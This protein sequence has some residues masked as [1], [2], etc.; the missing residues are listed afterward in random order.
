MKLFNMDLHISVIADFKN[1][2]P[3]IDVTDWTLS[4]HSWVFNK[5]TFYPNHINPSNWTSINES[6]IK[7]F[8]DEYDTFL[9]SFDGFICGHPN[10]FAMIFEKYNK[11]IL[12]I[13]SCRYDMP[14]CFSKDFGML[15]KYRECLY[16]LREKNLLTIVSNNRADQLYTKLGCGLDGILIP[17]LCKY[18]GMKY[19]PTYETFLNYSNNQISHPLITNITRPYNWNDISKYKGIIHFPYEIS[20]MSMFEQYSARIPLFFP[21]KEFMLQNCPI[22]SVSAYWTDSNIPENLSVFKCKQTW[23]DMADFY[24]TF[25]G[26]NVYLF[27]SIPELFSLLENF[28]WED[29][30]TILENYESEIRTSWNTIIQKLGVPTNIS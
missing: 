6:M 30:S 4:G 20:T 2:F 7:S 16:R 1:L 26:P 21:S 19:S 28:K 8:Q 5:Q 27:H 11:P 23:I 17:S 10:S 22:Q 25:K 13:N 9:S 12:L 18:T 15:E 29:D 3:E 14:F 24:D